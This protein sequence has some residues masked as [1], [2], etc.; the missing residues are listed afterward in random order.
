MGNGDWHC[1]ILGKYHYLRL[2]YRDKH[3]SQGNSATLAFIVHLW[4]V[5]DLSATNREICVYIYQ[6]VLKM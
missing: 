6:D 2:S 5:P 4:I 1:R 3:F